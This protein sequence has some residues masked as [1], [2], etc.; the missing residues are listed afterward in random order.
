MLLRLRALEPPRF[1]NQFARKTA[2]KTPFCRKQLAIMKAHQ[3]PTSQ[4][5]A[6]VPG[7]SLLPSVH[8]QLRP[9]KRPVS[10]TVV[11]PVSR[12]APRTTGFSY[13]RLTVAAIG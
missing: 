11:A 10:V 3:I 6:D 1:P 9:Q 5:R 7:A 4:E 8:L 13:S 2:R 12:R